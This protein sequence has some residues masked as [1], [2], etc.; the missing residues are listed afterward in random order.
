MENGG[1]QSLA[2]LIR[3]DHSISETLSK[4]YFKQILQGV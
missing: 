3:K 4:Q 2:G 1:K